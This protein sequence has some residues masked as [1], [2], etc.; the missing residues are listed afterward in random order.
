MRQVTPLLV[1]AAFWPVLPW[2]VSRLQDGSDDPVGLLPLA[3]ALGFLWRERQT[4]KQTSW[5]LT[6]ALSLVLL[7]LALHSQLPPMIEAGLMMGALAATTGILRHMPG[8]CQL[9]AL[10]LPIVASL[11]FYAGYPMRVLTAG[12]S[13]FCLNLCGCDVSRLGTTLIWQ[14]NEIGVDPPCSGVHLLWTCLLVASVLAARGR[15]TWAHSLRGW[16][17]AIIIAILGN[18]LR[19]TLLFPSE[20]GMMPPVAGYHNGI[21]LLASAVTLAALLVLLR[22]PAQP[23]VSSSHLPPTLLSQRL[24]LTLAGL[25]IVTAG[26]QTRHSSP[27]MAQPADVVW[28]SSFMGYVLEPLPLT[29]RELSFAEAFPGQLCRFRCGPGELI[30]RQV[31]RATRMLHSSRDCLRAAGFSIRPRSSMTDAAGRI[32]SSC[33]AEKPGIR[34]HVMER[35]YPAANSQE[36]WTDVSAWFWSAACTWILREA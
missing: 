4:L 20:S 25:C 6:A 9:L 32:W 18:G 15:W 1:I 17:V 33:A 28:P 8:V 31:N 19:S 3:V 23:L 22:R 14:G 7:Q 2:L 24:A 34:L 12:I 21:G 35:I 11:Q 27:T 26:W 30:L 13:C 29:Q 36:G 16:L 10:A 5:G